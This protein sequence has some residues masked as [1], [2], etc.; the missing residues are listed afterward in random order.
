MV[1]LLSRRGGRPSL[2][3]HSPLRRAEETAKEAASVFKPAPP[4]ERFL[5]LSN[6]IGGPELLA[7]LRE[8][9]AQVEE[10]LIVGHQPQLGELAALLAKSLFTISPGGLIALDLARE[11]A[12]VAWSRNPEELG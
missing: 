2:I 8:R 11:G 7:L 4:L 10:A 6:V 5:P 1:E 9:L 3:L 12:E